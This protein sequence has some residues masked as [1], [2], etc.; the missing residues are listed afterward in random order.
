[1]L[2]KEIAA[3]APILALLYDR[4][5]MA[6]SFQRA[7]KIRWKIYAGL[8]GTW[9]LILISLSTGLRGTMVGFHLGI[10]TLAYA[11]TE[12][13]VVAHYVRLALWPS[14]LTLDYYDWPI[15]WNWPDVTWRGRLV[16]LAVIGWAAALRYRP[17]LGFVGG[18]FFL[19]LAPTSSFLP[20]KMEAAAEQRMYLPLM[21]I[22]C[23]AVLGGWSIVRS[24]LLLRTAAELAYCA[25]VAALIVCTIRRNQ[26][27]QSGLEIWTDTVAKRPAN[28]RARFNLAESFA[29]ESLDL[30][31]GSAEEMAAINAATEQF[32]M[33]LVLEPQDNDAIYAVAQ[34]LERGG[35]LNGAEKVYTDAIARYPEIAANLLVERGNL[36][37]RQGNWPGARQDFLDAIKATPG[38]VEP[39]YFLGMLYKMLGDRPDAIAEL[40]AAANIDSK[41]KDVTAQLAALSSPGSPPA[42]APQ[43]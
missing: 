39:H 26:Q 27:Y 30:P 41:Y 18:W 14:D 4:A 17:W 43:H 23:L 24:R 15:A 28:P 16:M 32:K 6:G 5:F 22:V 10:S 2:T 7:L 38:D 42:P 29:Q 9:L 34:S 11:R 1:M 12:T 33:V 8:A 21:A 19:I 37:A 31:R 25:I 20:I 13:N 40:K 36:R 3:V 35:D